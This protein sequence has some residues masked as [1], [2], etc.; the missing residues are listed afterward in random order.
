M[1]HVLANSWPIPIRE[2][3]S[4]IRCKQVTAYITNDQRPDTAAT[5]SAIPVHII[6]NALTLMAETEVNQRKLDVKRTLTMTAS[7]DA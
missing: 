5:H 7:T 3:Y 4:T 2:P 1:T 6:R